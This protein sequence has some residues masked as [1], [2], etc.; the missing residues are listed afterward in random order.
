MNK[1]KYVILVS[2]LLAGCQQEL[3][4][5]VSPA[6]AAP[7]GLDAPR[8]ARGAEVYKTNCATCHGDQAQGAPNWSKKGPDGKFPPP[9]LD[10]QGHAWH[11]PMSMLVMT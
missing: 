10:A 8:V 7:H 2:F 1:F 9:P 3:S 6:V 5:V 4:Q 11:H